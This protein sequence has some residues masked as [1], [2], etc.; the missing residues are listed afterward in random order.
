M[1]RWCSPLLLFLLLLVPSPSLPSAPKRCPSPFF[2]QSRSPSPSSNGTT[3]RHSSPIHFYAVTQDCQ[4][5]LV[6][7]DQLGQLAALPVGTSHSA[8][9]DCAPSRIQLLWSLSSPGPS[10]LMIQQRAHNKI[11]LLPIEMPFLMTAQGSELFRYSLRNALQHFAHCHVTNATLPIE[12]NLLFGDSLYSDILYFLDPTS[13]PEAVWTVHQFHL[14]P[15]GHLRPRDTFRRVKPMLKNISHRKSFLRDGSPVLLASDPQRKRMF[16]VPRAQSDLAA[17][18]IQWTCP[19]D[20]I[21]RPELVQLHPL[22]MFP[23]SKSLLSPGSHLTGFAVDQNVAVFTESAAPNSLDTFVFV[24]KL[25]GKEA[26]SHCVLK[27]PYGVKFGVI[28]DQTLRELRTKGPLP[29]MEQSDTKARPKMTLAAAEEEAVIGDQP[30]FVIT[31]STPNTPR[32][33]VFSLKA[34]KSPPT[35]PTVVERVAPFWKATTA[36][37]TTTTTE[38]KLKL[39]EDDDDEGDEEGE[40][41]GGWSNDYEQL[42]GEEGGNVFPL[43]DDGRGPAQLRAK[44]PPAAGGKS[45]SQIGRSNAVGVGGRR[46]EEGTALFMPILLAVIAF[47]AGCPT[48]ICLF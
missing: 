9:A 6:R 18:S 11:C 31:G 2:R 24:A 44:T 22:A 20:L 13:T 30:N 3:P 43:T 1:S 23:R 33:H 19:F 27:L 40:E 38:R 42:P 16:A 41:G 12:P 5:V 46:L 35:K 45:V 26:E 8:A 34:H 36:A 29:P 48:E 7:P 32:G 25:R 37:T 28:S 21:F 15:S 47:F 10:L 4:F 17:E 14:S 39:E